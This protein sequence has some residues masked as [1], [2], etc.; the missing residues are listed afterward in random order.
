LSVEFRISVEG[1]ENF[2]RKMRKLNEA[3][4]E[5][6][7]QAIMETAEEI[8]LRAQQ[9]APVRTGWLMQ[10]IY[11]RVVEKYMVK[12]GCYVPYA[13][14]QEFGT[15]RIPPRHF[16]TRALQESA[17]KFIEIMTLAL[18]RAEAEASIE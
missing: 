12:V 7:R 11:A 4:K 13:L 18:Q 1:A 10:N 8:V 14:F 2:A 15:S 9:L 6:I 3:T 17:P 16:L 5:F